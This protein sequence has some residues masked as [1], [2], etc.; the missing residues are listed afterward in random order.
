MLAYDDTGTGTP[1]VFL[2]GLGS[3][4]RRWDPVCDALPDGVRCVAVDLPGHG[5]SP[6]AGSDGASAVGAVHALVDALG[7]HA[8]MVVGH[9]LGA[10][11]ALLYAAAFPTQTAV[12]VDPVGLDTLALA[13]ALRP[14]RD[15]LLSGDTV[16]AFWAFEEEHLL[17]ATASAERIRDGLSPRG[18]VI[19]SYWRGLLDDPDRIA[20]RQRH[21]AS[22]LASIRAPT[23]VVLADP[24]GD[25]A[26]AVLAGIDRA[27]VEVW[28]GTGHW[29]HL[30]DPERFAHRLTAWL[31][32]HDR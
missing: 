9:S 16:G 11:V 27:T 32:E 15:D 17:A 7:L 20:A 13:A 29:L 24:P 4:R 14:Y 10:I 28:A 2:H 26:T 5:D 12:A 22:A 21:F 19:R 6:D 31:A 8:P 3:S 23:L 18:E 25:G 1:I 30:D